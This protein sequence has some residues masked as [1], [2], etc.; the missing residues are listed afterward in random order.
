[1][2]PDAQENIPLTLDDQSGRLFVVT[3]KP[4]KLFVLNVKSGNVVASLPSVGDS[5]DMAFD[6]KHHRIYVSVAM[7]S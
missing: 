5:D 2:L 1:V 7:A 4:A 3:R 6:A